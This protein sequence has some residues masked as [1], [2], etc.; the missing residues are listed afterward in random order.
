MMTTT[1][2][3]IDAVSSQLE[4]VPDAIADLLQAL[5][6][7]TDPALTPLMRGAAHNLG[8]AHRYLTEVSGLLAR[9]S[10]ALGAETR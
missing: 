5:G 2:L 6:D 3:D 7:P 8:V 4:Q 9:A 1:S 10:D